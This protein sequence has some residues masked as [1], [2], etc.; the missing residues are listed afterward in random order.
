MPA[1]NERLTRSD[2]LDCGEYNAVYMCLIP[3]DVNKS[4]QLVGAKL[5]PIV[6]NYKLGYAVCV[7]NLFL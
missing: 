7:K 6:A 1:I 4:V 5:T 3:K 2:A